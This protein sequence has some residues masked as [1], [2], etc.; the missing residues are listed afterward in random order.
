M[1]EI[2]RFLL[3]ILIPTLISSALSII[4]SIKFI[5]KKLNNLNIGGVFMSNNKV[6]DNKG[7]GVVINK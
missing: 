4:I 7:G 3:S 2:I 5:S 1:E 6:W